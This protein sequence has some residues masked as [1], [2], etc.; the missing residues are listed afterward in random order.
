[1]AHTHWDR[2]WYLPFEE[3]RFWLVQALDELLD[4]LER[5]SDYSFMLDGQVI[6]L[7]DYL[8]IRPH[9]AERLRRFVQAG[10]L[11]IGPWYIQPDEFLVSGESLIRNLLFGRRVGGGFGPVMQQGYVPD[12]FGHIAQ[13]PQILQGFGI[14]TAFL[15]RGA[16]LACQQA[17]GAEFLWQAPD[18]SQVVAYALRA[19]YCSGA[20]LTD[21]L[22]QITPPAAELRERGL[23]PAHQPPLLALLSFLKEESAVGTLL[24]ANG[25][26]H[27]RPQP[28]LPQVV[29]RLSAALPGFRFQLTTLDEFALRLRAQAEKL[30]VVRGELRASRD[31]FVLSGV[32]S[33]RTYLKQRNH[34]VETL[35]E[36]YAEP[37]AAFSGL[38]ADDLRAF[39]HTAWGLLLQ[40]HAHDSICGCGVDAVHREMLTRFDRAESIARMV[41]SSALASLG[42]SAA[43]GLPEEGIPVIVFNPCPLPRTEEVEVAV[44][45]PAPDG[46]GCEWPHGWTLVDPQGRAVPFVARE[47]RLTSEQVL[48]GVRHERRQVIAFPARLPGVGLGVYRLVP[49]AP[50]PCGG[51]ALVGP[52]P[53]LE[54]EYLRVSVEENGTITVVDKRCGHRYQGLAFLEDTGDAGDEYNFSPP[55]RQQIVS[56]TAG[57][58]HVSVDQDLPWRGTLRVELKLTV[59]AELT[60]DRGA[61]SRRRVRCPAVLWVSLAPGTTQIDLA[62]EVDNAAR[63]HRLRLGFPTGI[64]TETSLAAGTFALLERPTRTAPG[65]GWVEPPSPTHP[66][67]GLVAVAEGKR[68]LAVLT[69][70]LLEYEA[71]PAGTIYVTLLRAVGWLSRADLSA[72]PGHAGPPY[73]VPDAQCPGR[74]RFQCAVLLYEPGQAGA[75]LLQ[76][77]QAFR[78]PPIGAWVPAA[79]PVGIRLPQE[80]ALLEVEPPDLVL[81]SIKPAEDGEGIVVRLYNPGPDKV[82]GSLRPLF[83]LAGARHLRLDETPVDELPYAAG[84]VR[85]TAQAGRIV[86]I[87][88][89]FAS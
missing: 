7:L 72:R 88:L 39:L 10:R 12:A 17:G 85:F 28:D 25:C 6:P 5:N 11:E 24:L 52:G 89:T 4:L 34:A 68:G 19:G 74:H 77:A 32:H 58:A 16:D 83:P 63:D 20:F 67:R 13:L 30:A 45:P 80:A 29:N 37:L 64:R 70:G 35:L 42:G 55:A 51:P 81:S 48:A 21:D 8:E 43:A 79:G 40:N 38:F 54:N 49:G 3:F 15:G 53:T 75:D 57:S 76:A 65:Q 27:L 41:T 18:G 82:H 36:C 22:G 87:G 60:P 59:P 9:Q 47:E 50:P 86:T 23:L 62:L 69:R 33:T 14:H 66:H 1:M 46:D 73:P 31:H 26:D 84:Q 61:R 2:E 44:P 71:T 56:S 78:A